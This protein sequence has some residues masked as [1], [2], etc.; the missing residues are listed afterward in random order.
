MD[1]TRDAMKESC[2]V[3]FVG[4]YEKYKVSVHHAGDNI[5]IV[6]NDHHNNVS[7]ILKHAIIFYIIFLLKKI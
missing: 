7:F 1:Q 5:V 6:E 3:H 4:T 2:M